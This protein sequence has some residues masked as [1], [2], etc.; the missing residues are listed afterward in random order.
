MF[1]KSLIGFCLALSLGAC[2]SGPPPAAKP[3][4]AVSGTTPVG[5]VGSTATRLPVNPN[6][7]AGF[8]STYSKQSL[9]QTGQPY[10]GD[11]LRMLD[12]SLTVH[13]GP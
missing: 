3:S 9:D 13:G 4:A 10:A 7:C 8:G 12:P 11:A 6:D 1:N 2:A 5:C